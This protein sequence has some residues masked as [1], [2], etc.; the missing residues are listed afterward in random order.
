M[1]GKAPCIYLQYRRKIQTSRKTD[2]I[3][4]T[5]NHHQTPAIDHIIII[6]SWGL[7]GNRVNLYANSVQ[8][9]TIAV[10]NRVITLNDSPLSNN[11]NA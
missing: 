6:R 9:R 8:M 1:L 5:Q 10:I 3:R 7:Q 2:N 4:I 11:N